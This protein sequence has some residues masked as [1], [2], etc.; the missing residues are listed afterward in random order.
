V[1]QPR[2]FLHRVNDTRTL[3]ETA[4]G[5]ASDGTGN[6]G[7]GASIIRSYTLNNPPPVTEE[8]IPYRR[9]VNSSGAGITLQTRVRFWNE[10]FTDSLLVEGAVGPAGGTGEFTG[11]I[12]INPAEVPDPCPRMDV[13]IRAVR[14]ASMGNQ[15][16]SWDLDGASW[17]DAPWVE[18]EPPAEELD[19][20]STRHAHRAESPTLTQ[21]HVLEVQSTRHAHRAASPELSVAASLEPESTRHLHRSDSP[22]LTQAHQLV[23]QGTRQPHRAGNAVL[24]VSGILEVDGTRHAHRA[25]VVELLQAHVLA[26]ADARHAHRAESPELSLAALLDAHSARPRP[27]GGEPGAH[28]CRGARRPGRQARPPG[29]GR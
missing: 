9:F 1:S 28:G 20:D 25:G 2:L 6:I 19:P 3:Q 24:S 17:V 8:G 27:P 7:G 22:A 4:G 18:G 13:E 15:S 21:A 5:D 26:P 10:F 14:A 29:G 11:T 16:A 12:P 23:V